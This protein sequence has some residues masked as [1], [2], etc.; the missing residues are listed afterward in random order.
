MK[1]YD[2]YARCTKNRKRNEMTIFD[3]DKQKYYNAEPGNDSERSVSL[4]DRIYSRVRRRIQEDVVFFIGI[5]IGWCLSLVSIFF[6]E[7]VL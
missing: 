1:Y 5:I 6:Y 2:S 7:V 4:E 3:K